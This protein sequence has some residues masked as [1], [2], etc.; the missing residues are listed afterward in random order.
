MRRARRR[1]EQTRRPGSSPS[2][3]AG[4]SSTSPIRAVVAERRLRGLLRVRVRANDAA[5]FQ[6]YGIN[7]HVA[8]AG[9]AER[10][11]PPARASQEDFLVVAGE[12]LLLIEGEERPS[13]GVGLRPLPD[14]DRARHRRR[15]DRPVRDPDGRLARGRA[16]CC[17]PVS[18]LAQKHGAGVDEET[19]EPRRGVRALPGVAAG[20]GRRSGPPLEL[21]RLLVRDLAQLVTPG[22]RRSAAPRA[23]RSARSRSSRTPTSSARTA[24]S[25]RS[26]AMRDLGPLDGDVDELDGRGLCAIPGLVD[27]HT[28]ACFAGDRV[29]EFALRAAGA[30]YEELHAAG[31]GILSTVRATRAAGEEALA[32][33]VAP[34][35]RLDAARAAR[36]RSRRSPATGSTATPSSRSCARSARPAASRPGSARTPS[37]PE[38]ADADA[39]LDFA[40][41]EVLPEAAQLAEAADVFLER[42]A[43]DAA[44]A[45]RYLDACRGRRPRAAPARRPV[46]RAGRDPARDRARRALGRPPRGDRAR[47]R[48][49]RW[50]RA[51]SPACCCRRARSSSAARCRRPAR[52]STPARRS[53]SRPTS[54][55]GS[56]FCESLPLVCSLAAT[57]LAALARPRRSPPAPSTPPTCSA[58]PT[59][60]AGIAPGY[61]ADLV[62]LDAPDWRYLA[63]HLGGDL[64]AAVVLGRRE[65][66][67][68]LDADADTEAAAPPAEGPAARV[69]VRLRRRR[70]PRGRGRA[71]GRRAPQ[72]KARA[73][74]RRQAAGEAPAAGGKE[75]AG[76]RRRARSSRRRGA[77]SA[78]A[79]AIFAPL[80]LIVV[81]LLKPQA[82]RPAASLIVQ[83]RR[84]CCSSSCRS[85]T[86]WTALM[87]RQ[88]PQADRR[89]DPAAR[90]QAA[91]ALVRRG[92]G[93]RP[94]TARAAAGAA[95]RRRATRPSAARRDRSGR[96]SP[97]P[98]STD[99]PPGRDLRPRR[100]RR[101][102]TRA[103]SPGGRRAPGPARARS[104]R[105]APRRP[106]AGRPASGSRPASRS[107]SGSSSARG[108]VPVPA[109]TG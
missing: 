44:Q 68:R 86:S 23:A 45:R 72:G 65:G 34:P 3:T 15:R 57:Q 61:D 69:R 64:V 16:R 21:S 63:Y 76:A 7:I 28:H 48:R 35:P 79:A 70:G 43:F 39:Y 18:E 101:A 2:T 56:A 37:R 49:A 47:R 22:R 55:P 29:E 88:L 71:R 25:P 24:G 106:S 12:C 85:A 26:G 99:S 36:R 80:M 62:L 66:G 4:S 19:D 103:P 31:G 6:E 54:T 53:R 38:F 93:P 13:E 94:A 74:V 108:S 11:V 58:A 75:P 89:P 60:R 91:V 17:Y 52:S 14:V 77:A 9:P 46:H 5:R 84:C 41:A 78:A 98:A 104:G 42:G 87:Y 92:S 30:T 97:A 95:R 51:T 105:R 83:R 59:A 100:P 8:L 1:L 96:A 107:P 33:A 40:L 102:P 82:T 67:A 90:A 50:P 109:A 20:A 73:G 10:H 81:Y 32:E 27:C